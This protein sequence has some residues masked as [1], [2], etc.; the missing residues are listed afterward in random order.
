[1]AAVVSVVAVMLALGLYPKVALD[2]I[3]PSTEGVVAWVDS[4]EPEQEGLPGGL[5]P[6][7]QEDY[8]PPTDLAAPL[9]DAP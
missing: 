2:R 4:V 9:E 7:V 3:N 6:A 1:V 5:R 8:V